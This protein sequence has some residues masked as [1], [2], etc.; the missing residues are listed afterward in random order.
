MEFTITD[1]IPQKPLRRIPI[2]EPLTTNNCTLPDKK[3]KDE[4]NE[5]SKSAEIVAEQS[6]RVS[7]GTADKNK[8]PAMIPTKSPNS[9]AQFYRTW[10]ELSE[11]IHKYSYLKVISYFNL[12]S[13]CSMIEL[14]ANLQRFCRINVI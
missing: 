11:D 14:S 6:K 4:E 9:S 2:N 1:T 12:R 13:E 8:V 5:A 10:R 7:N 3:S